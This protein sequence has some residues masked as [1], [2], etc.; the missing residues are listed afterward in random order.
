MGFARPRATAKRP[1]FL[2]KER[3]FGF[4]KKNRPIGIMPFSIPAVLVGT[5][6]ASIDRCRFSSACGT[7]RIPIGRLVPCGFVESSRPVRWM[8]AI[9]TAQNSGSGKR[10]FESRQTPRRS[11]ECGTL[12][13]GPKFSLGSQRGFLFRKKE[14]PF[15]PCRGTAHSR[16]PQAANPPWRSHKPLFP[17]RGQNPP[18]P[19]PQSLSL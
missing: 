5:V 14:T 10:G 3:P 7:T 2:R 17:L 15:G 16:R 19:W 1:F 9:E 8:Q 12:P 18:W 6:E 4:P 11:I 13:M